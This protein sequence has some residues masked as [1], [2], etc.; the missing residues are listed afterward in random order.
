MYSGPTDDN[1]TF[2]RDCETIMIPSGERQLIPEGTKAL[3]TQS[4]GG[5][6]TVVTNQGHMVRIAAKDA[7]AIGRL[8]ST[9]PADGAAPPESADEVEKLVWDQL[10]TVF[11][12]EIPVNIA[13]LGLVYRCE[14]QPIEPD[15][16]VE[17]AMTLTAPGCGMG[18]VLKAEVE[19]KIQAIPGVKEMDVE[20]VFDPPWDMSMMPEAAKLA[21]GLM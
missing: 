18:D 11:D 5:T 21:L 10:R 20:L 15:Y 16:R 12:P 4:L 7:D 17:I 1:V 8:S 9:D 6:Y 2:V 13:D 3:I 14:V 19:D